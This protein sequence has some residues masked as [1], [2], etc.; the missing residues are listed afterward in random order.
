MSGS[1]VALGVVTPATGNVPCRDPGSYAHGLLYK[2]TA[3]VEHG[4]P[5]P[6]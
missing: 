6:G 5:K 2:V 1:K 4:A 3:F